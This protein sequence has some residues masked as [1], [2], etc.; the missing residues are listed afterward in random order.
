MSVNTN[1]CCLPL[2]HCTLTALCV[3]QNMSLLRHYYIAAKV[4]NTQSKVSKNYE[5]KGVI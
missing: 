5:Q 3:P 2:Q 1:S 4:L